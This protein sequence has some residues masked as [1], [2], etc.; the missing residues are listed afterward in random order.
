MANQSSYSFTVYPLGDSAATIDLGAAINP[1]LNKKVLAMQEWIMKNRFAGL[2]DCIAAYSSLTVWY[3]PLQVKKAH[4]LTYSV[5]EWVKQ[6]LE[7]AWHHTDGIHFKETE[8]AIEI[9]VC[10]DDEWGVD[11]QQVANEKNISKHELIRLHSSRLYRV[12]M[13]GF[14]PGF[15]YMAELDEQLITPRKQQPVTV[16]KGS[17]GITGK[18]T[19]IYPLE[20]PGGWQIIGRTPLQLFDAGRELNPSLLRAGDQV[21]FIPIS[22]DVFENYP[23]NSLG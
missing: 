10:Y 21:K 2:S 11:L 4:P 3:N 13:I 5:F 16:A 8:R 22:R 19:G 14:L 6:Q 1:G 7:N 15:P 9:P 18:Q 20:S 12:Y 17:V 23:K